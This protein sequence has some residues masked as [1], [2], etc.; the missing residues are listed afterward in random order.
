MQEVLATAFHLSLLIEPLDEICLDLLNSLPRGKGKQPI[1]P[2]LDLWV[3][4]E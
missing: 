3:G 2:C 4:C 1:K